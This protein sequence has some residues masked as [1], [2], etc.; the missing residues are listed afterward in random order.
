VEMEEMR[1]EE[2]QHLQGTRKSAH[3]PSHPR[4]D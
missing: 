3:L 1:R 2:L 4:H